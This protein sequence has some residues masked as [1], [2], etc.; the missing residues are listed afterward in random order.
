MSRMRIAYGTDVSDRFVQHN[1][2]RLRVNRRH[3]LFAI[4][5]NVVRLRVDFCAELG[6]GPSVYANPTGGDYRLAGSP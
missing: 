6:Y 4:D 2:E 1:I 3:Y 5:P